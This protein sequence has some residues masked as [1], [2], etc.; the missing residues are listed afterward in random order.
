MVYNASYGP[1]LSPEDEA[2]RKLP[3]WPS[4]T[5]FPTDAA[6]ALAALQKGKIIVAATGNEREKIR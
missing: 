4:Y 3:S 2:N 1:V 5:I 6:A